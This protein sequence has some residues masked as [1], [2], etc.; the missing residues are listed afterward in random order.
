MLKVTEPAS[1][2]V[3]ASQHETGESAEKSGAPGGRTLTLFAH[4]RVGKVLGS[5]STKAFAGFLIGLG[6]AFSWTGFGGP[7]AGVGIILWV[8]STM[9]SIS[10]L[11]NQNDIS[12]VTHIGISALFGAAGATTALFNFAGAAALASMPTLA[13]AGGTVQY[14]AALAPIA[15]L[16]DA[17]AKKL[18]AFHHRRQAM[19]E[20][21]LPPNAGS[22]RTRPNHVP[23]IT[24][25]ESRP[26]SEIQIT[27]RQQ[28]K[29]K[30]TDQTASTVNLKKTT[31]Q[32][33]IIQQT[34]TRL[35]E[36]FDE[37]FIAYFR[38]PDTGKKLTLFCLPY[39]GSFD[40]IINKEQLQESI[41]DPDKEW[42]AI[43][44]TKNPLCYNLILASTYEKLPT[45][46]QA[47]RLTGRLNPVSR[48]PITST[49][50]GPALLA[51]LNSEPIAT[52]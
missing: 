7:I 14:F 34:K 30:E 11:E 16:I 23:T 43:L 41:G 10:G 40:G 13:Y 12:V 5:Y 36:V 8:A 47:G 39:S 29:T 3:L 27:A 46:D 35:M 45:L 1:N 21:P 51:L 25:P 2:L 42:M 50:A 38:K 6:L 19:Q 17:G 9:V 44:S 32:T 4:T 52:I 18:T 49:I 26:T 28:R 15:D 33:E 37:N 24:N 22:N 31:A 20:R 48:A